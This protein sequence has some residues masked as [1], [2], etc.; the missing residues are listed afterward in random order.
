VEAADRVALGVTL[1]DRGLEAGAELA[2]VLRERR[3]RGRPG[4]FCLGR[5][6][7]VRLADPVEEA[8]H[9][10]RAQVANARLTEHRHGVSERCRVDAPRVLLAAETG[11]PAVGPGGE[12]DLLRHPVATPGH[13]AAEGVEGTLRF[14]AVVADDLA[15]DLPLEADVGVVEGVAGAAVRTG[16]LRER[17]PRV[18]LAASLVTGLQ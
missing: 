5:L 15:H 17:R 6:A 13:V 10:R 11:E 7:G 9:V 4:G 12:G 1:G 3:R 18:E 14:L 16:R 2:Q 8:A